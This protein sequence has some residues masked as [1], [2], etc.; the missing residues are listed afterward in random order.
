MIQKNPFKSPANYLTCM[1]LSCGFI[2]LLLT[3]KEMLEPA[4]WLIAIA[5]VFDSLDG[6]VARALNDVTP[7][8]RELDSLADMVSFVVAPAFLTAHFL[9]GKFGVWVY[10]FLLSY[11]LAGGYRLARFNLGGI[12]AH[13]YFEGLP[14]PAAALVLTMSSLEVYRIHN[15]SLEL[16]ALLA[17]FLFVLAFLMV[18]RIPYPKFTGIPF[19]KWQFFLYSTI[20]FFVLFWMIRSLAMAVLACFFL[21]IFFGPA[22][23]WRKSSVESASKH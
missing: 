1:N 9:C 23:R 15:D 8:G 5:L 3:A 2:S 7:L 10:P 4:G 21:Y 22:I 16:G 11:L 14:T 13:F 17:F 20:A 12:S 19:P 6:N 18:S